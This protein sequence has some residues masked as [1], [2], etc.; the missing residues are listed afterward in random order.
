MYGF[1][2]G[3]YKVGSST[4]RKGLD[5]MFPSFRLMS[6]LLFTQLDLYPYAQ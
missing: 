2:L 5:C 1:K 6:V 4:Q 3:P